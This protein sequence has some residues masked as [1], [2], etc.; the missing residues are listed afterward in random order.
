[1]RLLKGLIRELSHELLRER[2]HA[3]VKGLD[4]IAFLTY[5]CTSCCKT[6][7][8]WQREGSGV[9]E[10]SREEW[11]EIIPGLARYGLRSF[12]I[13]GGDAILRKDA[14]YD[15]TSAC[16]DHG[17]ATYFPTN[18][19]LCDE[20]TVR[21]L[22][23]AGLGT[24][25]ISID[26]VDELHD[27]VRGVQGSFSKVRQALENFSRLRG[28]GETPSI[29]VCTTLSRLNFRNFP[30]LLSFLEQYPVQ[31]VYPRPL[32]E[33]S[34]ANIEAS[35]L[36]GKLPEPYFASSDGESH[37]M[38]AEELVE[39]RTMIRE[40][41]GGNYPFYVNWRTYYSTSDDTFLRGE[42]PRCHCRVATTVV[43]VNPNGD[44][45]PCPFFRSYVLGNLTREGIDS[46]WGNE[47]HRRFIQAQQR[48]NLAICRNCN[49]RVYYSS[50]SETIR[51]YLLRTAEA[52]GIFRKL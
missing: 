10:L 45:V 31:A 34:R 26:D 11:L 14:I 5:R 30:K 43:T 48:G 12:E 32:G 7:N 3:A 15:I 19:N 52:L 24:V 1:M 25:Y 20:E 37:L 27:Q 49:T 6:C 18:A 36:D 21:G 42:Y 35:S 17:I 4:S 38:S 23:E 40:V 9:G 44:V 22:I 41:R 47:P 29:V 39:M 13:F 51:Y 33:F 50:L 8:I 2:H 16:R 28:E 46:I